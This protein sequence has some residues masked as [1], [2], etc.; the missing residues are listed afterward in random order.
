MSEV[1]SVNGQT[2]AV[3][4]TAADVEAV[5]ESSVGVAGGVATLDGSGKL[6]EGQLPSSVERSS[7]VG[8]GVTDN[9]PTLQSLYNEGRHVNLGAGTFL[10]KTPVFDKTSGQ[11][12][13][14]VIEGTG[15][16]T[17]LKLGSEL[18]ACSSF[19]SSSSFLPGDPTM[20]WGFFL[21]TLE[22]ALVTP[23][24]AAARVTGTH[25]STSNIVTDG[26]GHLFACTVAGVTEGGAP[27]WNTTSGSTTTDG[28]VTW[29]CVGAGSAVDCGQGNTQRHSVS[30]GLVRLPRLIFRNLV[31]DG[32][33][34]N[35]GFVFGNGANVAFDKVIFQNWKVG[36]S[37]TGYTDGGDFTDCQGQSP[38]TAGSLPNA[39]LAYAIAQGDGK[40]FDTV[41]MY[42][43]CGHFA[44]SLC[45]GITTRS[46][47]GGGFWL[48]DCAGVDLTGWHCEQNQVAG[49][50][51]VPALKLSNTRVSVKASVLEPAK[52]AENYWCEINDESSEGSRATHLD[53][54]GCTPLIRYAN[55]P[56]RMFP[57]IYI[58]AA[59]TGTTVTQRNANAGTF[60]LSQSGVTPDCVQIASAIEG[61]TKAVANPKYEGAPNGLAAL[62]GDFILHQRGGVWVVD[63]YESLP[64]LRS[65]I[66]QATP[67]GLTVGAASGLLPTISSI[68][69]SGTAWT[70]TFATAHGLSP[71]SSIVLGGFT[72][73]EYNGTFT[74]ASVTSS[75]V[76][77]I[78]NGATPGAI[79]VTGTSCNVNNVS[80]TLTVGQSY[81][82]CIAT[83]DD[84]GGITAHTANAAF[85][86]TLTECISISATLSAPGTSVII[87]RKAGAAGSVLTEPEAFCILPWRSNKFLVRDLG[88]YVNGRPWITTS[89]PV[90]GT[91]FATTTANRSR[92][93]LNGT[94]VGTA[95][96]GTSL[97]LP[98]SVRTYKAP[99]ESTFETRH[100]IAESFSRLVG[101]NN[102]IIPASGQPLVG[103]VVAPAKKVISAIGIGVTLLEG[104]PANR[105]HLWMAL[106]NSSRE[107]LRLT[108]DFTSAT[109]VPFVGGTTNCLL[110]AST[111]ET[112]AEEILYVLFCEVM[113]ST[114]P[115]TIASREGFG[116]ANEPYTHGLGPTG[117]TTPGSLA[118]PVTLTTTGMHPYVVVA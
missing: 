66:P 2:G 97:L 82:Y 99:G 68:T 30:G 28:T 5:P 54:D 108:A 104:T 45:N 32:G 13:V 88:E 78:T 77:T 109:N 26:S 18:P 95:P 23:S 22:S 48:K 17:V 85:T 40:R 71:G 44:G 16:G 15:I 63:A 21:N 49:T 24:T 52:E 102:T 20:T 39:W 60:N 34:L 115:M 96:L 19:F 4:L 53:L 36:H 73:T 101:Y 89:V 29:T 80:G 59:N 84:D 87:W 112:L 81:D 111:Y 67:T 69:T 8:D 42:G 64:G 92:M 55:P 76:I 9:G 110:L 3:E 35:T 50:Q 94:E 106:L 6:P 117:N 12:E 51:L 46:C 38:S 86:A 100:V 25:Y 79:T 114:N 72:P 74:V 56:T 107:V 58:E 57:L 65:Y 27:S 98:N 118:S 113:S 31:L 93:T 11:S 37:W 90:P 33:A 1:T 43:G 83:I 61:I 103:A 70:V 47:I 75:T 14:W 116:W 105:T 62:A 91:A 41:K 10:V 7:G